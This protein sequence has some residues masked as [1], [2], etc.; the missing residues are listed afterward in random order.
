MTD[1]GQAAACPDSTP[2]NY[3][4]VEFPLGQVLITQGARA[5]LEELRQHPFALLMRHARGDWG[6]LCEEDQRANASALLYGSRLL[7]AYDLAPQQRLW[8][9]TEADRR[10]TTLLLP[11]EY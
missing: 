10:S 7:S 5:L 2:N 11:E 1:A 9:I 8:I 6:D 3:R 4:V